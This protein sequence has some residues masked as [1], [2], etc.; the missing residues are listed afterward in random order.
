MN[1]AQLGFGLF[2][3]Q[4]FAIFF[5]LAFAISSLHFYKKI[6]RQKL[7]A[8]FF[9]HHFWRWVL[10]G[11]ILG[12]V[13][14]VLTDP[15]VIFDYG[16]LGIFA[17]WEGGVSLWG[18][19][20]GTLW[21]MFFDMKRGKEDFFAWMDTA[22]GSVMIGVLII[23]LAAFLTGEIYGSP[24]NLP[25]GVQYETFGVPILLPVHPLMLYAFFA[26]FLLLHFIQRKRE[27]LRKR[28]EGHL[29]IFMATGLFFIDFFLQFLRGDQS[30]LQLG[31]IRVEQ[32][33]DVLMI[34][35]LF[36]FSKFH[37]K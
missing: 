19:A 34:V 6:Q 25:W 17:F 28:R 36:Y 21:T 30:M 16:F 13:V 22:V 3:V 27:V 20:L 4:T 31:F 8:D 33:I 15:Q 26:H 10:G 5:A 24:T 2:S 12:R 7:S 23:D 18:M 37:L 35:L 11:I 1:F 14:S 32:I 9:L 29:S